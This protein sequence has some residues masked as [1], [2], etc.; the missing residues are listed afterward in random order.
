MCWHFD[1]K[2]QEQIFEDNPVWFEIS[3]MGVMGR[4]TRPLGITRPLPDI[5]P[6]RLR[7][8]S[9]EIDFPISSTAKV[10]QLI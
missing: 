5:T 3:G 10:F 7:P 9:G 8:M 6:A 4:F 1:K 2:A